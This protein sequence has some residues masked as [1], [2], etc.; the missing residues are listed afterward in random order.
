[1]NSKQQS[2]T[3][4]LG[5]KCIPKKKKKKINFKINITNNLTTSQYVQAPYPRYSNRKSSKNTS[6][7]SQ[8]SVADNSYVD[9][10]TIH[11]LSMAAQ[12]VMRKIYKRILIK[13]TI[14]CF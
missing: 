2:D 9:T 10:F 7:R 11:S 8:K 5:M 14:A 6:P 4:V 1:M 12:N 13:C 3:I